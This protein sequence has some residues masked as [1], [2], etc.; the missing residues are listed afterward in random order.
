MYLV[1]R[2]GRLLLARVEDHREQ[3]MSVDF[4][5]SQLRMRQSRIS[6]KSEPLLRA[7]GCQG[8]NKPAVVDATA[9]FGRDAFLMAAYGCRVTLL[10][11]SPVVAAL[12]RDGLQRAGENSNL[13]EIITR[14]TLHQ[15]NAHRALAELKPAPD[16]IYLDP[17]FPPRSKSAKVK[18]EM[19]LLH[20]LLGIPDEK[21]NA[22][23]L[24]VALHKAAGRVVVKRPKTTKPLAGMKP[25]H[26]IN[27][28]TMRFDVYVI[29]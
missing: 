7:I 10:E 26:T 20:Q 9:G 27:T 17:M 11:Q 13:R 12:L 22:R 24:Q 2:N 1:Y 21:A 8:E 5:S 3:S 25:S 23:L 16:V 19:Q 18:K 28:K 6:R 4:L 14:M 29:H 15:V